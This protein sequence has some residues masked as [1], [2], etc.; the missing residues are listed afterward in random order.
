[1]PVNITIKDTDNRPSNNYIDDPENNF[2]LNE[3]SNKPINKN[4]NYDDILRN[5]GMREIK[6]KLF[7]EQNVSTNKDNDNF[8]PYDP[9]IKNKTSSPPPPPPSQNS[10]I[11]NKYFKNEFKQPEEVQKP[12]NLIEYRNMLIKQLIERKRVEQIKSRQMIFR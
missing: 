11:Y 1:M 12:R 5:M 8:V 9:K 4:I 3:Y 7:W 2:S 6:G 10:Y